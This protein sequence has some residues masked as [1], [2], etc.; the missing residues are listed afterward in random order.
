MGKKANKSIEAGSGGQTP[1]PV[2]CGQKA[3]DLP[4]GYFCAKYKIPQKIK[5]GTYYFPSPKTSPFLFCSV[6]GIIKNE[7]HFSLEGERI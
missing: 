5:P 7:R 6:C 4:D 3:L 1:L 2:F